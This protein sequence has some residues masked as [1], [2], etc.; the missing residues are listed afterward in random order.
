MCVRACALGLANLGG[1]GP[2]ACVF[3]CC[4]LCVC[5]R[6]CVCVCHK[7]I[8]DLAAGSSCTNTYRHTRA[9]THAHTYVCNNLFLS[10]VF[11][12]HTQSMWV[13]DLSKPPTYARTHTHTHTHTLISKPFTA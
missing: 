12:P 3:V 6:V 4:V 7:P 9:H 5:V 8:R 1:E 10:K 13:C 11:R 2:V